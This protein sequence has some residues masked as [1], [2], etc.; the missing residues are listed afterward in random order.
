VNAAAPEPGRSELTRGALLVLTAAVLWSSSGLFIKVLTLHAVALTGLR[1][2][3]A[4]LTL[5]PWVRWRAVRLD[6]TLAVLTLAHAATT[7]L[8]VTST[9]WT[10][11]AN[12][13]ALMS[14]AP[15]WV[16]LLG[17]LAARR[18]EVP[19]LWPLGLIGAG[20]AAMLAEPT[21]GTSLQGNLLGLAAGFTFAVV[22]MCFKRI[23]QPAVGVVVLSNLGTALVCVALAPHAFRLAEIPPWEWAGLVFLGAFQIGVPFLCFTAGLRRI[24]VHQ[25]SVLVLV[26][27][28]LNPLWVY[29]VLR[30]LP[31]A[32]G[33]AG[34]ALI[35][36]GIVTDFLLRLWLPSLQPRPGGAA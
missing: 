31:S 19:L 10:T 35:F 5:A 11:A 24:T 14:T 20:I 30:E 15:G 6:R 25:A 34:Y 32:Y 36:A 33:F 1:A 28:L 3:M 22:Q 16:F 13:I 23:N 8:F 4:A 7:L 2:L 18:F 17:G 29:L 9:R 26:E 12:A 27:P 21:Q